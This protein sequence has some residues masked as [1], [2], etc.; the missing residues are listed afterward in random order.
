MKW[1]YIVYNF[2]KSL[3]YLTLFGHLNYKKY[4]WI[5]QFFHWLVNLFH[6]IQ[7]PFALVWTKLGQVQ[8]TFNKE[9]EHKILHREKSWIWPFQ[10]IA[11][12]IKTINRILYSWIHLGKW[13]LRY[14]HCYCLLSWHTNGS[15]LLFRPPSQFNSTSLLTL[16][17][18][19]T[20]YDSDS[21]QDSLNGQL[22]SFLSLTMMAII[23]NMA[24]WYKPMIR[25]S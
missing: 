18:V 19:L 1:K 23:W 16:T 3:I 5:I 11:L 12:V 9:T 14:I 7:Y 25:I 15:D 10:D 17:M 22:L 8:S 13:Y 20:A 6:A 4:A 2:D 24:W 21:P